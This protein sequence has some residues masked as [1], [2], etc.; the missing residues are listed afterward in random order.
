MQAPPSGPRPV[1]A[2]RSARLPVKEEVAGA[3]TGTLTGM[4]L[5][6]L[7]WLAGYL[8]GEGS[9]TSPT[10]SAPNRPRIQV[11]ATDED[12]VQRTAV[13]WGVSSRC[14]SRVQI[15]YVAPRLR[16]WS[17]GVLATLSRW[18]PRV[19]IPHSAPHAIV[20]ERLQAPAFQAGDE[21]S[22]PSDG[23][24]IVP[25]L[26]RSRRWSGWSRTPSRKRLGAGRPLGG[27]SPSAS[28]G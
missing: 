19:R 12:V 13:L 14:R 5:D 9:F 4:T 10:P 25:R 3:T 21:G 18:R 11:A 17:C 6:D 23:S 7:L 2:V 16:R 22:S 24:K 1:G 26:F 28:A 8:E 27:S 15:P 20:A